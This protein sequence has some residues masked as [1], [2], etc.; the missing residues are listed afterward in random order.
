[1][2]FG[3]TEKLHIN[4]TIL[5]CIIIAVLLCLCFRIVKTNSMPPMEDVYSCAYDEW[6]EKEATIIYKYD[7]QTKSM[8]EI[9]R[10]EGHFFT[11]KLTVERNILL[12]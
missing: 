8:N 9:G 11:A 1:M 6:A 2:K 3:I 7:A 10:V 4:K 5:A 12:D